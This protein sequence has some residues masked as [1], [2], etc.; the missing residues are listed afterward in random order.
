[1]TD[2]PVRESVTVAYIDHNALPAL[3]DERAPIVI[4]LCKTGMLV[5]YFISCVVFQEVL[6]ALRFIREWKL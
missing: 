2:V 1:M 5:E 3:M 6:I 4:V